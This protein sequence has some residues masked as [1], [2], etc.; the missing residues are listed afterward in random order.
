MP[1]VDPLRL[2][3]LRTYAAWVA[4]DR[5]AQPRLTQD[6]AAGKAT[7]RNERASR[8][9]AG[10]V[11]KLAS[12]CCAHRLFGATAIMLT[13]PI[14]E[15]SAFDACDLDTALNTLRPAPG[16]TDPGAAPSDVA[17][18]PRGA[19]R[20]GPCLGRVASPWPAALQ[21]L[22]LRV[23]RARLPPLAA[24]ADA[25][26][27]HARVGAVA[28]ASASN[29]AATA[30]AAGRGARAGAAACRSASR[31]R[32]GRRARKP[33]SRGRSQRPAPRAHSVLTQAKK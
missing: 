18:R 31:C 8:H 33:P 19:A 21:P 15:A 29:E 25:G 26:L 9:R 16:A 3:A 14:L 5:R 20:R 10:T 4:R 11:L 24:E 30:R 12:N 13:E 1:F 6:N 27:P 23:Q 2:R 17:A 32:V 7:R 22:G 28:V